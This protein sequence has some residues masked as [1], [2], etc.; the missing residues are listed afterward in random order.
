MP[1]ESNIQA[2]SSPSEADIFSVSRL[3]RE[4]RKLLESGLAKLWVAGELSNVARPA[5]GHIYFTLKDD[6]AQIR[7]AMFR[8]SN[9]GLKFRPANGTQVMVQARVSIY[10]ARGDYQLIVDRMEES[11]E[12]LLRRKFEELKQQLDT[13]GLFAAEHK[14]PL[15][16]LPRSI[17]IVTS[18]TGAAVRDILH[19]LKRRYP[20]A[21]VII[22]PTRVQG[23]GSAAEIAN[24]IKLADKRAECDVMIVARGG[25]SLEDLWSF[26]EAE[27]AH[28]I[29]N[30]SLPIISGVGHE[31]DFT[32]AD[33]VAD[34][35]A[36]TPSGA[37]E[38]VVPERE[39]LLRILA[40][41]EQRA[42]LSLKRLREVQQLLLKQLDERLQRVH[43]GAVL[44]QLRLRTDDLSKRLIEGTAQQIAE[45]QAEHRR[46][47]Q[48]LNNAAPLDRLAHLSIRLNAQRRELGSEIRRIIET[49][50][51]R[52]AIAASS[53]HAVSPLAT[54]DRGYA[55]VSD[56][57]TGT[58]V[59]NADAVQPGDQIKARLASGQ[60]EATVDKILPE[61]D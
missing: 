34:V 17:G 40:S 33:L 18:P 12:G 13:A 60:V 39:E 41:L 1:P 4:A 11:G 7:C 15:P 58:V 46:F 22:Y 45:Q 54:L 59:I 37:A 44:D 24:A 8:A 16:E 57:K 51:S 36:P 30:C 2:S 47:S 32:I 3:N 50:S 20:A 27:V 29:Y 14:K 23:E 6:Q 5:S 49:Y 26:N 48:R 42:T 56:S 52:T 31:V 53:L 38:L 55:I 10:E 28:A 19:I 9:R 25:G 35:R 61:D 43:P 21:D